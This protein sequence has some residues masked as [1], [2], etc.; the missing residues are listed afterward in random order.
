[1]SKV[2]ARN[3]IVYAGHR[4]DV[5]ASSNFRQKWNDGLLRRGAMLS[6]PWRSRFERAIN[7]AIKAAL[8]VGQIDEDRRVELGRLI[9]ASIIEAMEGKYDERNQS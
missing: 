9:M 3:I 2:I 4:S 6:L 7:D 1:M 8:E 5:T